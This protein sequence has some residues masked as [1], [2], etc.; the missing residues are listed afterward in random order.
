MDFTEGLGMPVLGEECPLTMP[1]W[2]GLSATTS[3]A[4]ERYVKSEQ[5]PGHAKAV[6]VAQ[7]FRVL[8]LEP[9]CLG[10]NLR[11]ATASY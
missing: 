9:D 10:L 4:A 5:Y 8:A 7:Q 1:A 6:R 2:G 3:P 11:W